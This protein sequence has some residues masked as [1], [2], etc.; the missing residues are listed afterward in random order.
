M[1]GETFFQKGSPLQSENFWRFGTFCGKGSE[2]RNF[3][4]GVFRRKIFPLKYEK[5]LGRGGKG[6]AFF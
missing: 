2:K 3:G 6:N 5:F 4:K 1:V